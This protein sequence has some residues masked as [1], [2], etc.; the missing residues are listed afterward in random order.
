MICGNNEKIREQLENVSQRMRPFSVI[1][2][3]DQ[4]PL[5]MAAADIVYTKPG[6]LTSTETAVAGKSL[7]HTFRSRAVR[8]R[9]GVSCQPWNVHVCSFPLALAKV[10]VKLLNSPEIQEK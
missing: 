10:G 9:T 2:Y 1:G 7:I 5:Y 8:R 4:M 6:G 3:T